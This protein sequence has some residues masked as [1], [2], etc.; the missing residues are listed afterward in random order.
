MGRGI[1][2]NEEITVKSIVLDMYEM[3]QSNKITERETGN[4]ISVQ[5][6]QYMFYQEIEN[7]AG[8]LGIDLDEKE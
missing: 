7:L 4:E 2:M 5:D 3:S 8:L 1:K 6:L